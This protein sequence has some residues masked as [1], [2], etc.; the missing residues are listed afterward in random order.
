M[1]LTLRN[2][3]VQSSRFPSVM[4]LLG[5]IFV[6]FSFGDLLIGI[7]IYSFFPVP[8]YIPFISLESVSFFMASL[9]CLTIAF[10]VARARQN[11]SQ[12]F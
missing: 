10:V 12:D 5:L 11:K 9:L 4:F 2:T 6:L 8:A 7:S 3:G 1:K